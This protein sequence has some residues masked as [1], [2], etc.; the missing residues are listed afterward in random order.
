MT[1]AIDH[2][3]WNLLRRVLQFCSRCLSGTYIWRREV[4]HYV[5]GTSITTILPRLGSDR[6]GLRTHHKAITIEFAR[7]FTASRLEGSRNTAALAG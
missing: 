1:G 2:A 3:Y 5:A 6:I 4:S 7:V